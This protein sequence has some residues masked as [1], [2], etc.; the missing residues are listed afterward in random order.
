MDKV[1]LLQKAYRELRDELYA[2]P[3][4]SVSKALERLEDADNLLWFALN[5][6]YEEELAELLYR[7]ASDYDL[8]LLA[9]GSTLSDSGDSQYWEEAFGMVRW[10]LKEKARKRKAYWKVINDLRYDGALGDYEA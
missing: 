6:V 4:L 5:D 3:K 10:R 7:Y 9:V 1:N 2:V 8:A